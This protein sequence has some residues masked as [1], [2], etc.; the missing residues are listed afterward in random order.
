MTTKVEILRSG[1][2]TA[3]ANPYRPGTPRHAQ[4]QREI[5]AAARG[6]EFA[7]LTGRIGATA[8]GV[9]RAATIARGEVAHFAAPEQ[10]AQ[11]ALT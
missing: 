1:A 2:N 10:P 6:A 3:A 8:E 5:D 11:H 4:R 7:E 9:I